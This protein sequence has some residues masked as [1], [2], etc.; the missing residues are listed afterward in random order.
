[1]CLC[2]E[3][4]R[5]CLGYEV[6]LQLWCYMF[7]HFR[8]IL[9]VIIL[10]LTLT[11]TACSGNPRPDNAGPGE[12]AAVKVE[13]QGFT[14]MTIYAAS[15]STNRVRLGMV[16]GNTTQVFSVPAFLVGRGGT[17]RFLADPV[18]GNRA[19]VS[20]EISVEAGDTIG[21]TIPPQ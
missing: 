6:P 12:P 18:G 4:V 15:E 5:A 8:S 20:E 16:V 7:V 3:P 9:S 13:N 1:M 11:A 19:P 17:V 2:G 21:L 14:D 10:A